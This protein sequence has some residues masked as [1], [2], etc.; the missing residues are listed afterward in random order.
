MADLMQVGQQW[1]ADKLIA[2]ASRSVTYRRGAALVTLNAT[3]GTSIL[4]V[5]DGLGGISIERTDRDYLLKAVDLGALAPPCAGDRIDDDSEQYEVLAP[6]GEPVYRQ[7]DPFSIMLRV[8]CK[9][10]N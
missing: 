6:K 10:V 4:K 5:S 1:L 8:H 9:K 3:I 2:T 7:S